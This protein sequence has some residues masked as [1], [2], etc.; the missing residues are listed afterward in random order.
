MHVVKVKRRK[1][2]TIKKRRETHT[3]TRIDEHTEIDKKLCLYVVTYS[4]LLSHALWNK[5]QS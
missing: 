1:K 4:Q 2:E 5:N 3:H